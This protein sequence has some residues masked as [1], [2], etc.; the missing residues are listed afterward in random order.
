MKLKVERLA[1]R[2]QMIKIGQKIC[3]SIILFASIP[4]VVV[5]AQVI[6]D[7]SLSSSVQQLQEIMKINGG[8]RA[9]NNL[10]HSFDEFSI[11]EGIEA[12]FENSLDVEN[13]FTRITGD[14]ISNIEGILKT[15][16]TANLFLINPSGII[17]G[18]NASIDVGGSFIATTAD[19]IEF[20]D[21]KQFSASDIDSNPIL[22]VDFPI[23]LGFG[24]DVNSGEIVVNGDGNQIVSASSISPVE[25]EQK[26]TGISVPSDKT[27]AL[28]GNKVSLNGGVITTSGGQIY[29]YSVN[30]G[31]VGINQAE[32]DSKLSFTNNNTTGYEDINLNQKSLIDGSSTK[33]SNI[34]LVG[35]NINLSDSSFILYQNKGNLSAGS[36]NINATEAISLSGVSNDVGSNIRSET[37]DS[38]KGANINISATRLSTQ[39]F[40]KIRSNSF[41]TGSGGDI[42]VNV[43]D[44]VQLDG[45]SIIAT[46]FDEGN[47]GNISLS[48]SKLLLTD[49]GIVASSTFGD[50]QGGK[51]NINAD[52]IE[53][54]GS[55]PIERSSIS[56]SSFGNGDAGN[57]TITTSQLKVANGASISSSSFGDG[58][59][60]SITVNASKSIE[61]NGIN[62]D[63]KSGSNPESTIRTA[64]QAVSSAGQKAFGLP[65]IPSGNSGNL[66]LNTPLL[67]IFQQASVNVENGGSGNAGTVFINTNNLNLEEAGSITASSAS[68]KGGDINITSNNLQIDDGSFITATAGNN[69]EGGNVNI[70]TTNLTAK[71]NSEITTNAVEGDGGNIVIDSDT[72]LGIENSDIT[73]NA[74]NGNGGN[75]A[76]NSE[77]I[78]GFESRSQ[79]TPFNDITAT[80][81]FG[82][83]GTVTVNSPDNNLDK[84][85][86]TSFRVYAPTP[87]EEL[88]K[89][90]C[91]NPKSSRGKLINVGRGGIP[92][93][94]DHFFNDDEIVAVQGVGENDEHSFKNGEPQVWVEGDPIIEP[95]AVKVG[96]DGETYLVS[97]T[98]L[99]D[100]ESGVCTR[101]AKNP[102]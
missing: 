44:S 85:V 68:G 6:P 96:R 16:G 19:D 12:I 24:S 56:A 89:R 76:I 45:S 83:D 69:G 95:N 27:F 39:D 80:S 11:P 75:I 67:N 59:A 34:D 28:I 73:A 43:F 32:N 36:L 81:D 30:S 71:K 29:L 77:A 5:K 90:R 50:G 97:Q 8:E 23:G 86:F 40:T 98:S 88:L 17:F 31:S 70:N 63:F 102:Q 35:K 38:G 55:S 49:I 58:D 99:E 37:L 14:S 53:I 79:L 51:L 65:A 42:S 52:T 87:T 101:E 3:L 92:E 13:I 74:I 21:G 94:P 4:A 57:A 82:I 33:A 93:S 91:L 46:T 100:A 66:T 54:S 26:P 22:T 10:F 61:V 9:G 78:L 7:G 48:T 2:R 60:G 84:D 64:V 41:G 1:F 18:K 15:Q 62:S 72:I 47:A 25:F 20:E